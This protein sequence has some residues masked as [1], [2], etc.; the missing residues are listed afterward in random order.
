M[1]AARGQAASGLRLDGGSCRLRDGRAEESVVVVV[2]IRRVVGQVR[3]RCRAYEMFPAQMLTRRWRRLRGVFFWWAQGA[4]VGLVGV[5]IG[6]G[7]HGE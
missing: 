3:R 2:V 6:H 7:C 4:G 5:G 1:V